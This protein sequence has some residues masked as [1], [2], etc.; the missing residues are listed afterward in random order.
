MSSCSAT[1]A[2]SLSRLQATAGSSCGINHLCIARNLIG[3]SSR[4]VLCVLPAPKTPAMANVDRPDWR[5]EARESAIER[6][7]ALSVPAAAHNCWPNPEVFCSVEL[8]GDLERVGN[9]QG[10]RFVVEGHRGH[11]QQMISRDRSTDLSKAEDG[12]PNGAGL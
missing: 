6:M 9:S 12:K 5:A 1:S 2:L 8:I 7:W 11:L 3:A 4:R 10:R